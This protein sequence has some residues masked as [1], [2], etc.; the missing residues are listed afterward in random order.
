MSGRRIEIRGTVQGV[1]FRPWVYRLARRARARR[2]RAQRRPS[3]VTIEAF[4]PRGARS[5][6]ASARAIRRRPP[7]SASCMRQR[8]RREPST[9]F[10]IVDSDEGA[11]RR[12]SIPADLADLRGLPV[13]EIVRSRR[14][15]GSAI[16]SPTARTAARASRSPRRALRPAGDDD[17]GV[18]H[19]RGLPARVRH[20]RRSPLPCA[21]QCVSVRAARTSRWSS[22]MARSSSTDPMARRV[23][24]LVAARSSPSRGS[25][26]SISRATPRRRRGARLRERKRRDEKPFAVM[27]R[28]LARRW[29]VAVLTST[30][31]VCSSRVE[32][33]IVLA[34]DEGRCGLA[35]EVAPGNPL[36]GLMLPYTPLHH[37]CSCARSAGLVMTS[38]NLS[39]RADRA[40][41][42]R[43]SRGSETSRTFLLH[44]RDIETPCDDSVAR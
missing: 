17:G 36:V 37:C 32:R 1:G 12:V 34:N 18:S 16:R 41:Q 8:F 21:A 13:A 26:D 9:T 35:A 11:D 43:R 42:R 14:T 27:V 39:R 30:K 24:A 44:D 22:R 23:A 19:V 28:D 40:S 2:S 6:C 20:G 25:A 5:L 33:P 4:G 7:T 29:R 15:A 31:S 38:G 10:T 3:G